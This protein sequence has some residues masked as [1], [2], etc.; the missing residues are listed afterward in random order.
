MSLPILLTSCGPLKERSPKGDDSKVTRTEGVDRSPLIALLIMGPN[1]IQE[2]SDY[3]LGSRFGPFNSRKTWRA[4][5]F[6]C[7]YR[8][9]SVNSF[10]AGG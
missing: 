6:D 5:A 2:G 7:V 4:L 10:R 1:E 3:V 8:S 9:I